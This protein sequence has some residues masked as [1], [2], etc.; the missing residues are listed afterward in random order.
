[1]LVLATMVAVDGVQCHINR[2]YEIKIPTL[3][4]ASEDCFSIPFRLK[5]EARSDFRVS[6]FTLRISTV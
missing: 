4:P 3:I 2:T 5:E 6:G 1:M